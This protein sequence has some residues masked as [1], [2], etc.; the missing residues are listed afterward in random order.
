MGLQDTRQEIACDLASGRGCL[1]NFIFVKDAAFNAKTRE[2]P[3]L[4][5]IRQTYKASRAEIVCELKAIR[6]ERHTRV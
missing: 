6:E 5:N 3:P 4:R 2:T 1:M